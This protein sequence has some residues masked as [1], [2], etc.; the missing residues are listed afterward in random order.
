MKV[1]VF[2][3]KPDQIMSLSSFVAKSIQPENIYAVSFKQL[4]SQELELIGG[5]G[6][7]KLFILP[8]KNWTNGSA[9]ASSVLSELVKKVGFDLVAVYASKKGNEVAARVAQRLNAPYA[10]EIF[11]LEK[12]DDTIAAKRLVLGGGYSAS[13][14]FRDKPAV[15]SVKA[16]AEQVTAGPKPEVEQFDLT[17]DGPM[18][19]FLESVKPEKS[20]VDLEKASVVVAVGRGFKKKEDL[21]LA[22]ELA[23]L[24]GAE[25]GCSRPI[26]G[27]LKWLE[28]ER[29]IGLSGKRVRPNLYI[30]L[31]ISGQVQHLVGMRDSK[32]VVAVNTDPNAP[33][34]SESDYYFVA[35]LYKLLPL[36]LDFLKK[37]LG[38]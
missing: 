31:G 12:S 5:A 11:S 6:V 16:P 3:E 23:K 36:S 30:A 8:E 17:A 9:T 25:V 34:A 7:R 2:G 29:H 1:L 15:A 24:I 14:L 35:D 33:M 18:V 13:V 10:A 27:D 37:K 28:E 21:A 4:S 20:R 22:E 26:S 19:E 38:R 32:T